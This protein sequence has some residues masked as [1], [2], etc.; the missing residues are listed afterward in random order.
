MATL[1]I[2]FEW[3][4]DREGY[5]PVQQPPGK[6]R[7][8]RY[9]HLV[10]RGGDLQTIRPLDN[11]DRLFQLFSKLDGEPQSCA[12]F[13]SKFGPLTELGNDQDGEDLSKWRDDIKWMQDRVQLFE[14]DA[15]ELASRLEGVRIAELIAML[16]PQQ[17]GR[18]QLVH[19]P[20]DLSNALRL[21]LLHKVTSDHPVKICRWCHEWFE[22]GPRAGRRGG[23]IF[24]SEKCKV[25]HHNHLKTTGG[26][27]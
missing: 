2:H 7:R 24:C 11:F 13:A 6:R 23:A 9:T 3:R 8:Y 5:L 12:D 17:S 27:T 10:P 21:Q 15:G 20:I 18:P 4:R 25:N 22:T 16:R 14:E 1:A 19:V 26:A